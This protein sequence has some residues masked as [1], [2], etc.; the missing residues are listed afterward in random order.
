MPLSAPPVPSEPPKPRNCGPLTG[1]GS[2]PLA[3]AKAIAGLSRP[4]SFKAAVFALAFGALGELACGRRRGRLGGALQVLL[5]PRDQF[6]QIVGLLGQL[7]GRRALRL[8]VLLGV[9]LLAL[10]L[11]D[12]RGQALLLGREAVAVG[13]QPLLLLGRL[14]CAADEIRRD[15]RSGVRR[16]RAYPAPPRRAASRR[17]ALQRILRAHQ[18]GRRRAAPGALQRG[19]HLGDQGAAAFERVADRRSRHRACAAGSRSS[20]IAP[21]DAA[22]AAAMSSSGVELVAVLADRGDL[23]LQLGLGLDRVALLIARLLEFLLVLLDDVFDRRRRVR[24]SAAGPRA[25]RGTA[26]RA[27]APSSAVMRGIDGRQQGERSGEQREHGGSAA[28]RIGDCVRSPPSCESG[29][30]RAFSASHAR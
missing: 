3:A 17:A 19:Q 25:G 21:L 20:P 16:A 9:A 15:R 10:P 5:H 29:F 12:Q 28:C 7:G 26:V 14:V 23:G 22:H 13:E 4:G 6:A 30:R 18:Q 8:H 24:G 1:I 27:S 2:R 11:V